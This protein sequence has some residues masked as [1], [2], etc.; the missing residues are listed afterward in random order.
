MKI[1]YVECN[2]GVAGDMLMSALYEIIPNK[3]DFLDKINSIF[4]NTVKVTETKE[5]KCGISGTRLTVEIN[6][7]EEESVDVFNKEP[8]ADTL[9]KT[10]EHHC[11]DVSQ[12][13]HNHTDLNGVSQIIE[14]LD[15]DEIVKNNARQIYQ[16]IA[17]AE[18][19]AHKMTVEQIHFHEL[20]E[21]DAIVDIVGSCLVLEQLNV[22]K[23]VVSPINLGSGFVKCAHGILPVPAPATAELIKGMEAFSSEIKGELA[24]PTGVA[25]LKHF[26]NEFSTM[27]RM[28]I[29][30][31]GYGMGKKDFEKANCV[32]VFVGKTKENTDTIAEISCNIDD[33]TSEE[34]G[35]A[36]D[37]LLK[38]GA[39]DVFVTPIYMKK[40]RPSYLLSC[41]CKACDVD[42]YSQI[43]LENTTTLGVRISVMERKILNREIETLQTS[44]G[45]IRVKK[46]IGN[47]ISHC[48]IEYD[49]IAKIAN[50][51]GLPFIEVKNRLQK[52]IEQLNKNK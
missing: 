8:I 19:K 48:K 13:T 33:M 50:E 14:H 24:T 7:I 43:T 38:N 21:L 40:N 2:M 52:E 5:R 45:E 34:I 9:K 37:R 39:L 32:R 30:N 47:G 41:I 15:V 16:Y 29:E 42:K 3:Q 4:L 36:M 44:F 31:V 26:A 35:F 27:P 10:A 17:I 22:D 25:V 46:S 11:G 18:S 12:L 49:D 51:K 28:E 1:L 20:G 6:G 23:V